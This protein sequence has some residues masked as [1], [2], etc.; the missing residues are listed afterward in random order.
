MVARWKAPEFR[1]SPDSDRPTAFRVGPPTP[2]TTPIG[3]RLRASSSLCATE[4]PALRPTRCRCPEFYAAAAER[5][6]PAGRFLLVHRIELSRGSRFPLEGHVILI[7]PPIRIPKPPLPLIGFPPRSTFCV[8]PYLLFGALYRARKE[9][10][11]N[12]LITF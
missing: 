10:K 9:R 5:G 7:S 4:Y 1:I 11:E 6:N 3:A 2:P 12:A 8:D